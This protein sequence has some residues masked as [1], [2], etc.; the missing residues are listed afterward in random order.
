V[1]NRAGDDTTD[2]RPDP[3]ERERGDDE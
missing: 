1:T 2:D 3:D